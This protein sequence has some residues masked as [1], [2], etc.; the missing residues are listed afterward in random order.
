MG[1]EC[2]KRVP[3]RK[4]ERLINMVSAYYY[5]GILS[6][7]FIWINYLKRK[8][9]E[10]FYHPFEMVGAYLLTR[11]VPLYIYNEYTNNIYFMLLIDMVIVGGIFL[12]CQKG[13]N[14]GIIRNKVMIFLMNPIPCLCIMEESYIYMAML[15][16][17]V[18]IGVLFVWYLGKNLPDFGM[19]VFYKEYIAG[20]ASLFFLFVATDYYGQTLEQCIKVEGEF[21]ILL[22]WSLV[23]LGFVWFSCMR[24]ILGWEQVKE[25]PSISNDMSDEV[26]GIEDKLRRKDI[27]FIIILSFAYGF[28]LFW[29]LGSRDVPETSQLLSKENREIVIDLGKEKDVSQMQIFLGYEG[30]RSFN[31]YSKK[32]DEDDWSLMNYNYELSSVFAWNN[33][34][35]DRRVRYLCLELN[36][37]E[38]YVNEIV[39]L[40][41]EQN[42]L[43]PVNK[44]DYMTLFDEQNCYP[45]HNTYYYRTMFDEVY[46]ARTAYEF[47]HDLPIYENTHPPLGKTLIGIGIKQ[48]GMNP[49]GW[50]CVCAIFG[51]LIVPVTYV[52]LWMISHKRKIAGAGSILM[53]TEFMHFTLSRIATID[54]IVAFFVLMT[55]MLMYGYVDVFKKQRPFKEQYLYLVLCGI[56][57]G[58]SVA[59]K[60]TGAYAAIGIAVIFFVTILPYYI[61]KGWGKDTRKELFCL[62]VVCVGAF[63]LIPGVIYVLSYVQFAQV[64]TD[65]GIIQHCI[66][67]ANLML[68]YHSDTIFAHPY[69]SA[70]YTWLV[71][72]QPLLDALTIIDEDKVSTIATFGNPLIVWGGLAVLLHQVFLWRIRKDEKARFLVLSYLTMIVPWIFIKRTVFIYQYFICILLMVI[73]I[74]YSLSKIREHQ[75]RW[76]GAVTTIS[77]GLFVLYYPVLSGKMVSIDFVNQVLELFDSWRFV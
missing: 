64:Y 51:M 47:I 28:L 17:S 1:S 36:N 71:D 58:L 39:I 5:L 67:N 29:K 27:L 4:K 68:T 59:V 18:G 52:F 16:I 23:I 43:N 56:F 54:I 46:H 24:K 15:S 48:F 26:P 53:C 41:S 62:G 37:E 45:K 22:I 63:I 55:F 31:F 69:S 40:D 60:W 14:I 76:I 25:V 70:W 38:A 57:V 19:R 65:K 77:V 21:P 74:G 12:W 42:V 3:R 44:Q 32:E 61:R 35:V 49:F 9:G 66:E 13:K 2:G 10:V 20:T 72:K 8:R 6:S 30:K 75:N 11:I 50:R 34:N 33:V 7:I 73:M